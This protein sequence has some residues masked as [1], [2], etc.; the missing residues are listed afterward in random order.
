[1]AT[2]LATGRWTSR[3][4]SAGLRAEGTRSV[5]RG[6]SSIHHASHRR[7]HH[8][9]RGH[10]R[11]IDRPFA[12]PARQGARAR[13]RGAAGLPLHRPLGGAVHG[14]LRDAAGARADHRQPAVLRGPA[15]R[16]RRAS[17]ARQPRRD[18]GRRPTARRPS[19]TRT[20]R[21]CSRSRRA[22]SCSTRPAPA[23]SRPCF[24]A[25]SCSARSTS[26]TPPTWTC[27]PSTRVSCAACVAPAARS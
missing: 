14:K 6:C 7:L 26:P 27:T 16:L 19:C 23:P 9:W 25:S 10:R 11:R 13:A 22:A 18:D 2:N 20:G 17:A 12:G 4:S 8:H 1:M 5:R 3:C 24:G 21:C 15:C